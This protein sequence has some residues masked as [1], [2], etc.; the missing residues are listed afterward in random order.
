ME[1]HL[2][3]MCDSGS[4]T[5]R[6]F[7]TKATRTSEPAMQ[8][9]D[10]EAPPAED[11]ATQY[12][13]MEVEQRLYDWWEQSGYFKPA[14]DN[15]KECFVISMP[16]PNVTGKLH[17]G[18][19]MF[20]AL[21]DIMARFQRM[22]GRPTLWLPGTDHAGIA[23]Q[24]LVERALRTEG[25]ERK[26]LG[27]EGFLERVWDWKGEYGGYITG[28]IRR[29]GASCDWSREKFTLQPEL[30]EAVT[31]AFVTL[32]E[33]GLVYKGDRMVNWSPNLGTAVRASPQ[34]EASKYNPRPECR[35]GMPIRNA[36]SE[37][38]D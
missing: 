12:Q 35:F 5:C 34:A 37:C 2:H 8:A 1:E 11:M 24:M 29:L 15:G 7:T 3:A 33:R 18:H 31:E 13:P 9:V 26:E 16:P 28:Q 36:D 22:R 20:V 19:A 4:R 25:I 17:M 14:P 30:C 27:R 21:E 23:T 38:R 32:H 10:C 6:L